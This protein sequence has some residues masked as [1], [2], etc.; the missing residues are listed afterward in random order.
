[1]GTVLSAINLIGEA[2]IPERTAYVAKC[3]CFDSPAFQFFFSLALEERAPSTRAGSTDRAPILCDA[4]GSFG[5]Y[6]PE[7]A[8][9]SLLGGGEKIL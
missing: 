2:R 7:R 5:I 3:R 4:L 6:R 8:T 1:M 9:A